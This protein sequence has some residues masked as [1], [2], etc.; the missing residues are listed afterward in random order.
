MQGKVTPCNV[1]R[2][3]E[4]AQTTQRKSYLRDDNVLYKCS[5]EW[6]QVGW[7]ERYLGGSTGN[8]VI[9][10]GWGES[11]G[12]VMG[13][14][15]A[16][17]GLCIWVQQYKLTGVPLLIYN[18]SHCIPQYFTLYFHERFIFIVQMM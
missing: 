9:D 11:Q 4:K 3:L 17:F 8:L 13:E 7:M 10:G 5:W 18:K 15:Y 6:I 1:E 14:R 12:G 16:G 2:G